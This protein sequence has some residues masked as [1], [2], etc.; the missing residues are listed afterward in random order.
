MGYFK[1]E[2]CEES[3]ESYSSPYF[4]PEGKC[5]HSGDSFLR[6]S[7]PW[8]VIRE[9]DRADHYIRKIHFILLDMKEMNI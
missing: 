5:R 7:E 1:G 3:G 6:A 9:T 4:V 2:G 8:K